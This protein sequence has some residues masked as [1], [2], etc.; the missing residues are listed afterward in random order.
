MHPKAR[1]RVSETPACRFFCSL[2][3]LLLLAQQGC[4]KQSRPKYEI[5]GTV[6]LDGKPQETGDILFIAQDNSSSEG[7]K[8]EGGRYR[9]R[10]AAGQYKVVIN[11]SV[12]KRNPYPAG[13][14]ADE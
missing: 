13:M 4:G 6:T 9:V 10:A 1:R 11:A 14:R 7:G 2:L 3:S 5:T 8:I 12:R